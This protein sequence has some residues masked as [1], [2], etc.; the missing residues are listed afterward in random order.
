MDMWSPFRDAVLRQ[1]PKAPIVFDRFHYQRHIAAA[2]R[3]AL[4][5]CQE[6]L[7]P[8]QWRAVEQCPGKPCTCG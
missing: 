1:S 6:D 8:W 7:A 2:H 4:M 3:E 5:W